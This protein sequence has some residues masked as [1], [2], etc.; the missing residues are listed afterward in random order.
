MIEIRPATPDEMP[1]L[2]RMVSAALALDP[3]SISDLAPEMSLCVF[4]DDR[5]AAVHG[6][7]PLT[8]RFNGKA[9]PISGVTTVATPPADRGKGHLRR[10]I[11]QHFKELHEQQERPI[12]VLYASQAEIYQRFGYAIVSTHH[13]YRVEPRFLEFVEPLQIPGTVREVD[14]ERDFSLIVD[15][16][17]AYREERTGLLH[18]GQPMWRAG[19]FSPV[20]SPEDAKQVVVYE[21]DGE[22]LGYCVYTT[23]NDPER[24]PPEPGQ[25]LVINDLAALTPRAYQ[26]FWR[27]L[28]GFRLA[29]FIDWPQAPDDDPLPHLLQ[30]PRML[31]DTAR[32]GIL[33]RI[34]DLPA[35]IDARGYTSAASLRVD[36]IDE[37][38]PWNAGTW[39]IDL[40]PEG[41]RVKQLAAGEPDLSMTINTF[42]MLLFGQ[43]T[44]TRAARA[45]RIGV[46]DPEALERWDSVLA[47]RYAPFCAD[48]F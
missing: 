36:L 18:R 37:L 17:R 34:V 33:A 12:A 14:Q 23:G 31:R 21:E 13:R 39:S 9:V 19:V 6:S 24:Q 8:M 46:H 41:T 25:R 22:P 30:E 48:N 29:R 47:T 43:L 20:K 42:A 3:T 28:S 15:L 32:D 26:A 5:L 10:L 40:S 1:E 27:H 7:W 2:R 35:A 4:D 38:C 16:Y 11:T 45:G 44:A